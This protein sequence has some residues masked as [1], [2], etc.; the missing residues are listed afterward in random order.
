M[1]VVK[2]EEKDGKRTKSVVYG[3]SASVIDPNWNNMCKVKIMT[4]EQAGETKV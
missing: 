2:E 3:Q 1:V 4:G